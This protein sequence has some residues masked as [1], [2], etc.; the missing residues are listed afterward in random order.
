MIENKSTSVSTATPK[1]G[2][3]KRQQIDHSSRAMFLWVAGASVIVAFALVSAI[4]IFQNIIFKEK[5]LNAKNETASRLS[6][7]IQISEE[8]NQEI[9]LLQGNRALGQISSPTQKTNNLDKIF[10]ALPYD[11]DEIA[12]GSSLE[13]T[14]LTGLNIENLSVGE[15]ASV[16]ET[17]APS[18]GTATNAQSISFGFKAS[19]TEEQLKGLF[20]KLNRSIR[21]ITINSLQIEP[22]GD[23]RLTAT[24]SASTFYQSPTKFE[25]TKKVIK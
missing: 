4:F 15:Q 7:N 21:P 24:V 20:T 9:K 3:R 11:N 12:V 10:A 13:S 18:E 19:G 5:I 14:L 17:I 2:M 22:A 23:N 6:Q 25:L 16:T 1:G 8:L